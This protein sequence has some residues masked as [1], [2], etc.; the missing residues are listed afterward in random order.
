MSA[1][2]RKE[3]PMP[4]SGAGLLRFFE[5][6]SKGIKV[7]PEI[8]IGASAALIIIVTVLRFLAPV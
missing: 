2:K 6:E 7:R 3:A 5:E 1:K 4:A 8:V